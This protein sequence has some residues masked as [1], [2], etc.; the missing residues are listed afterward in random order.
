[1]IFYN[2]FEVILTDFIFLWKLNKFFH[3]VKWLVFYS[4]NKVKKKKKENI[5]KDVRNL[6]GLTKETDDNIIKSKRNP[7]L[8]QKK[9]KKAVKDK[10][11]ID[12]GNLF[13]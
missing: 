8:N 10:I 5:I 6:F 13:E 9:R 11:I 4:L 7:F 12:I 3:S 2:T 1:M